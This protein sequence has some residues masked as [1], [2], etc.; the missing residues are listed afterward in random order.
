MFFL[1]GL[2]FFVLVCFSFCFVY[3]LTGWDV[4]VCVWFFV[5]CIVWGFYPVC[6]FGFFWLV[7]GGLCF[8]FS[9]KVGRRMK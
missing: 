3:L 8:V 1:F 5:F 9:F 7:F 6:F 4:C 2:C